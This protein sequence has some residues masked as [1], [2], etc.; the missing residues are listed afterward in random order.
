M[1][2]VLVGFDI[3]DGLGYRL[4]YFVWRHRVAFALGAITVAAAALRFATLGDQ[5]LD[6]DETVTAARVLHGDFFRS[7]GVVVRGERSP[8]LYYALIWLWS[9]GW[10]TGVV[11]L[12]SLSAVL[13]TLTVVVAYLAGREFAARRAGLIAALLVAVNPYLI[14]YSQ[15]A[16]SYGAL[17][18]FGTLGLYFFARARRGQARR[19]LLGWAVASG[20]ALLTHYFAVFFIVPEALLLLLWSA[21]ARRRAT[22]AAVAAV[23]L[24]G[25]AL[26]PLAVVQEGAGRGNGFTLFPVTQ[27]AET[28]LVKYVTVEGAAPQAGILS[29]TP[30][31][32]ELGLIAAGLV[33]LAILLVSVRGSPSERRG[34]AAAGGVAVA[35]FGVPLLMAWSG[36]D[37]VDPRNLIGAVVPALVALGIAMSVRGA[38]VGALCVAGCVALFAYGLHAEATT[39][40]MQ[41]H[42]WQAAASTLPKRHAAELYVVPQDGRTP[43]M[44]YTGRKL[45]KFVPNHFAGG[46]ATRR[47]VVVSDYPQ[48]HSPDPRFRLAR[49]KTAPQHWTVDTYSSPRPVVITPDRL[50][51]EKIM[52]QPATLLAG[53]KPVLL[54]A[55]Q[56]ADRRAAEAR[57]SEVG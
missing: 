22:I 29:T 18:M 34:A 8:P 1:G 39:P 6:H 3:G 14:W 56:R 31:E 16:R 48:V 54:A 50:A 52:P 44:Y 47:I 51:R 15:E 28:A 2:G 57:H 11:A 46:V 40:A 9:R 37:F 53:G 10:G 30:V 32:R 20:L 5:S 17:V 26:A 36:F 21:P 49:S 19:S 25:L 4:M 42:D 35:A 24:V 13:G 41:R 27:R 43:L 23:A 38:G 33:L 12:R 7:M 45:D 55:E